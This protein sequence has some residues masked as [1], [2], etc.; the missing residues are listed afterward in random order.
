[1]G[2]SSPRASFWVAAAPSCD[3]NLSRPST[4]AVVCPSSRAIAFG[5]RPSSSASD[6][7]TCAS[8]SAVRVRGGALA[9]SKSRLCSMLSVE[10]STTTGT[11]S[12]PS[13][14]QRRRRLKPSTTSHPPA[15]LAT[16][17]KGKFA[18]KAVRKQTGGAP[19][20]SAA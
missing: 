16:T 10:D 14:C 13:S 19:G 6:E 1:M 4:Q 12:H 20:R 3:F 17:R 5:V 9:A 7:T 15:E 8:S 11:S 18:T 2:P